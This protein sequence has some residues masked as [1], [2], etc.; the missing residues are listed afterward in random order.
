MTLEALILVLLAGVNSCLG[1]L[2]LKHSRSIA[3]ADAAFLEKMVNP[4]FAA[5]IA[6][7]V[8]NVVLFAKALDTAPVSIAYPILASSAFLLLTVASALVFKEQ[9]SLPQIAGLVLTVGGIALL[10]RSG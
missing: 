7:Y 4:F 1:N 3:P 9:I 8:V 6:F 5:G 10:A 2:A